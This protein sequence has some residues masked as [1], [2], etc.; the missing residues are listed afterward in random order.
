MDGTPYR[1][2]GEDAEGQGPRLAREYILIER[3]EA[4]KAVARQKKQ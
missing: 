4:E 3:E 2:Y 1:R